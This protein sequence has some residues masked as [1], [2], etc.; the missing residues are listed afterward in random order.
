[1]EIPESE[2]QISDQYAVQSA[3]G[4]GTNNYTVSQLNRYVATVANRGTVYKLTLIDKTTDSNGKIIKE[5]EPTVVN[6][7]D[8]ISSNSW[9]LV[10]QGMIGMVQYDATFSGLDFSMAGKTGTAADGEAF[11]YIGDRD[12]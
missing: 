12:G 9:D 2:P 10:H 7:M 4:Q 3:I 1:M 6:T 8:E 11:Q 5:Y